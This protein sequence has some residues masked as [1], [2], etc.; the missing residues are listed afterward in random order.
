MRFAPSRSVMVSVVLVTVSGAAPF[1]SIVM[2][3]VLWASCTPSS[4]NRDT[5]Q[6]QLVDPESSIP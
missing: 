6:K 5:M 3:M 1:P 4:D 2:S